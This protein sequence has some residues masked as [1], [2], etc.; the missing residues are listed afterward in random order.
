MADSPILTTYL[1]NT[2]ALAKRP[3][4]KLFKGLALAQTKSKELGVERNVG[5]TAE[6]YKTKWLNERP[7]GIAVG[8]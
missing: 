3:V 6:Q 4:S 2:F 1:I 8:F 7:F 5:V